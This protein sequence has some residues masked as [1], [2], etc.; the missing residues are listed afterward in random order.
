MT[1]YKPS[2]HPA[3]YPEQKPTMD[4]QQPSNSAHHADLDDLDKEM[5]HEAHQQQD[6]DFP[7]DEPPPPYPEPREEEPV[8]N[9]HYSWIP[10]SPPNHVP[11][12]AVLAVPSPPQPS[13]SSSAPPQVAHQLYNSTLLSF[14][15]IP[16]ASNRPFPAPGAPP[17][18]PSTSRRS[19]SCT[20]SIT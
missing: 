13:P 9:E 6:Q 2:S 10:P 11:N 7:R 16:R 20:S 19:T 14:R 1:Y 8:P 4:Y 3:M 15:K 5:L 12:N 17:S 18:P